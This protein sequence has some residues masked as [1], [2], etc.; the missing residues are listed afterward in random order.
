MRLELPAVNQIAQMCIRFF[1]IEAERW[2][3][4]SS[5]R[6]IFVLTYIAARR[7]FPKNHVKQTTGY[8]ALPR[9]EHLF[10]GMSSKETLA[11]LVLPFLSRAVRRKDHSVP[12]DTCWASIRHRRLLLLGRFCDSKTFCH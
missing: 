6:G 12:L 7:H 3:L 1:Y 4:S 9:R 8:N 2:Q 5:R 11:C 10:Y